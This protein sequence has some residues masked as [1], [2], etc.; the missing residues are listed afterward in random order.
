M[1]PGTEESLTAPPLQGKRN[2]TFPT[3][4][5]TKRSLWLISYMSADVTLALVRVLEPMTLLIKALDKNT[6][7]ATNLSK[8]V[9]TLVTQN[10][11]AGEY[12]GSRQVKWIVFIAAC[13]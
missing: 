10:G 11:F 3:R 2:G 8:R 9:D 1:E 6:T 12:C 4:S 13:K 5:V 7:A